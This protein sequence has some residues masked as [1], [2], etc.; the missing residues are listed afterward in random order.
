M[1]PDSS[2]KTSIR[3]AGPVDELRNESPRCTLTRRHFP[4]GQHRIQLHVDAGW[5]TV[6]TRFE[7]FAFFP[8]DMIGDTLRSEAYTVSI[9]DQG[10][11]DASKLE[12]TA[13]ARFVLLP[14]DT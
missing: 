3:R 9:S 2:E 10:P 5:S 4:S 8:T 14:N 12:P 1:I 6:P 7:S 11:V 13:N